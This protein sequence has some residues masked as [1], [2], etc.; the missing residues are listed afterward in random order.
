MCDDSPSFRAA[1]I[2]RYGW[3]F[4]SMLFWSRG[5]D[6]MLT[7]WLVL[8]TIR[9]NKVLAHCRNKTLMRNFHG[10]RAV[11]QYVCGRPV[12]MALP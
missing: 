1:R 2:K 8:Y 9:Y 7:W 6:W 12:S 10:A 11:V 3:H 5:G 4:R